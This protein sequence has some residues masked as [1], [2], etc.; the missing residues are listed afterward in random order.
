MAVNGCDYPARRVHGF[1]KERRWLRLPEVAPPAPLETNSKPDGTRQQRP[2]LD[3][4]PDAVYVRMPAERCPPSR[5]VPYMFCADPSADFPVIASRDVMDAARVHGLPYTFIR[6]KR[7]HPIG[8]FRLAP[9]PIEGSPMGDFLTARRQNVKDKLSGNAKRLRSLAPALACRCPPA[10][11]L[12]RLR[13]RTSSS[14]RQSL[15]S[16]GQTP[17]DLPKHT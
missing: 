12:S 17:I 1:R 6:D 2:G 7:H 10:F 9:P 4:R 11:D 14:V 15:Q 5:A 16:H 13:R 8:G 3:K